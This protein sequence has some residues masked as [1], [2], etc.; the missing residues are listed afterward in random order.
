[1]EGLVALLIVGGAAWFWYDTQGVGE[2]AHR[3]CK[4]MCLELNLQ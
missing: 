4:T 1:M 2:I 3:V